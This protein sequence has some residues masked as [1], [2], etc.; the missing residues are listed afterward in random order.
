MAISRILNF[1]TM[2]ITHLERAKQVDIFGPPTA[3]PNFSDV[4]HRIQ[5]L[6]F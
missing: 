4:Y 6:G 1:R 3:C 5:L 2:A